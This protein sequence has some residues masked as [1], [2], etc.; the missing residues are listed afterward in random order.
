SPPGCR[1]S[2]CYRNR[3]RMAAVL[4][5]R[6]PRRIGRFELERELGRGA[7]GAVF[8]AT[9][10]R[11]GRKVALKTLHVEAAS[12]EDVRTL[13]DEA[14]IVSTLQ[15][16]NIVTLFDAGEEGKAPY[17]VFEYVEGQTL[18][19]LIRDKG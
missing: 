7:Q 1:C 8:L 17:L 14:R 5:S 10:M 19:E 3:N 15:H 6:S 11:L 2:S 4:Q 13:L 12:A 18:A 9:D 16:P